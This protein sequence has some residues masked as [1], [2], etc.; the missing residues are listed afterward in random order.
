MT[1]PYKFI[2]TIELVSGTRDEI[3]ARASEAQSVTRAEDGCLSLHGRWP[4]GYLVPTSSR[5]LQSL[6]VLKHTDKNSN[7]H[8]TNFS[9]ILTDWQ[10]STFTR[11]SVTLYW[12]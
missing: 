9:G 5:L 10:M 4:N 6:T 8:S 3:V 12:L 1:T 7:L 11:S 2:V